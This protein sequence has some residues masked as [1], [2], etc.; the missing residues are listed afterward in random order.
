MCGS[1]LN[2]KAAHKVRACLSWQSDY[3]SL[4]PTIYNCTHISMTNLIL[5]IIVS[6]EFTVVP[7]VLCLFT[8]HKHTMQF[9]VRYLSNSRSKKGA[10]SRTFRLWRSSSAT[11]NCFCSWPLWSKRPTINLLSCYMKCSDT[12][13]KV[14]CRSMSL[15]HITMQFL[16]CMR[17][18]WNTSPYWWLSWW[19][20]SD[21]GG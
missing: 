13:K 6:N 10:N 14:C 15:Y 4:C 3:L 2:Q 8:S 19:I 12:S 17:N 1:T 7:C 11:K 20:S 5:S 16:Y 21:V 9:S 18:V